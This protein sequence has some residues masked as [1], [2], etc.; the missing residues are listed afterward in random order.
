MAVY[1]HSNTSRFNLNSRISTQCRQHTIFAG[2][3]DGLEDGGCRWRTSLTSGTRLDSGPMPSKTG[4]DKE[5]IRAESANT[6]RSRRLQRRTFVANGR[7]FA[8]SEDLRRRS[9]AFWRVP[10]SSSACP[11]ITFTF[12]P[13]PPSDD[14]LSPTPLPTPCAAGNKTAPRMQSN[15]AAWWKR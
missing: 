5:S 3:I 9:M 1:M 11:L 4:L 8:R 2:D 13:S 6:T 7:T 12:I 14:A 15:R 10:S